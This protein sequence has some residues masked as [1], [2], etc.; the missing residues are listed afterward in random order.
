MREAVAEC[1]R[2]IGK[3]YRTGHTVDNT[4]VECNSSIDIESAAVIDAAEQLSAAYGNTVVT[5]IEC[6]IYTNS[7]RSSGGNHITLAAVGEVSGNTVLVTLGETIKVQMS[8]TDG[9]SAAVDQI[10]I[11]VIIIIIICPADLAFSTGKG[12]V[13]SIS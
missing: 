9:D 13:V 6:S 8:G 5:V 12:E 11:I 7:K 10:I 3:F 2:N 4:A 1:D